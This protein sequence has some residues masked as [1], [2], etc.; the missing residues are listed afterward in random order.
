MARNDELLFSY[1]NLGAQPFDYL[2]I[3]AKDADAE[4]RWFYPAYESAA[5]NPLSIAIARGRANVPLGELVQ[6]EV[7]DG[8]L[9][10]YALFTTRPL[11][12]LEVEAWLKQRGS[13]ANEAPVA[14]GVLQ[15]IEIRVGR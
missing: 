13:Q 9:A 7:A 14:D 3:F 1:T 11:S 15:R 4:V 8:P 12:V 2:M 6:Q 10:L 5:E